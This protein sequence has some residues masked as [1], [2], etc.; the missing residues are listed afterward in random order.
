MPTPRMNRPGLW[1]GR[2]NV[3][4]KRGM[5]CTSQPLASSAA[6]EVL[7]R[8][9]NAIDAAI[10]AS[11]TLASVE[12]LSTG[13]GGDMF[14]IYWSAK[15]KKLK[16]INGSG[17]CPRN[18]SWRTFARRGINVIPNFGWP[19]VTVPGCVDGW[20][21]L[22]QADGRLPWKDL[23]DAP[24]EYARNGFPVSE[25]IFG[26]ME[27]I[28]PKLQN[29]EARRIFLPN[30]EPPH[31]G[32]V[33]KQADLARSFELIAAGGTDAFYKGE[34]A[35][36]IVKSSEASG[37]FFSME[38]FTGHTSLWQTPL[39]AT[40][41]GVDVYE[42]PP[43][44]HGIAALL[45]LNILSSLDLEKLQKD[46][47]ALTH[48]TIEAVKLAFAE[49]NAH[50]ADPEQSK[51]AIEEILS[52]TFATHVGMTI[53]NERAIVRK[54]SLV[55]SAGDTVY[56]CT[57]D[58][59]GNMVS[60]I[61]SLYSGSGV[62]AGN[63]GIHLQNRGACFT[64]ED[65]HPN[66][67]GPL[68]RP[69]HTIIPGFAMRHGEPYMAFGVMGGNHQPQGHVQVLVN[70]LLHGMTLQE[71]L[72]APRFDFRTENFVALENDFPEAIRSD[73]AKRGH[74]IV[75]DDSGPFGGGQMLR[76]ID[77]GVIEGASDPRKDGCAIGF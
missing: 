38:D 66:R 16:S 59:E 41:R 54:E 25:V 18:L 17:R 7:R 53:D 43:N 39:K 24:I 68:K 14:A 27:N 5:A 30:G 44:T 57:A 50:V 58:G 74:R 19:S 6:L 55:K 60:L 71:S 10:T 73:L 48:A 77:G 29:D 20:Y 70:F 21:Q 47:A 65:G 22:H 1:P 9:G 3:L 64:L 51:A 52:L 67:I 31:Y 23:F 37:G 28:G 56:L 13:I 32:Q 33:F 8:G 75:E 42:M 76:F 15:E 34:I 69:L 62:V 2:S 12:P 49:R 46:W 61:S 45:A 26:N 35:A 36:N 4:A 11:A 40:F 72:S 63:T